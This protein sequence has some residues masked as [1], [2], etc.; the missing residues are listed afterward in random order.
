MFVQE[1]IV[2]K[3]GSTREKSIGSTS[4]RWKM[5]YFSNQNSQNTKPAAC[6]VQLYKVVAVTDG[7]NKTKIRIF[8]LSE[9]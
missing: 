1:N 2:V 7:K 8:A 4:F 6:M 3:Q 9:E 5:Q